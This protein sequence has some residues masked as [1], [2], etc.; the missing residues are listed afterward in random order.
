MNHLF[1][2]DVVNAVVI[3]DYIVDAVDNNYFD[4]DTV[5]VAVVVDDI[6]VVEIALILVL[7]ALLMVILDF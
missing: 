4:Y 5:V 2:A 6:V 7:V 1:V 3:D